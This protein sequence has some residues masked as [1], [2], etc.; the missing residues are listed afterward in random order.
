MDSLRRQTRTRVSL[1]PPSTPLAF[2]GEDPDDPPP[3]GT[4]AGPQPLSSGGSS[5]AGVEEQP[6]SQRSG[7]TE[8]STKSSPAA[9]AIGVVRRRK[10]QDRHYYEPFPKDSFSACEVLGTNQV[11]LLATATPGEL[12]QSHYLVNFQRRIKNRLFT[13]TGRKFLVPACQDGYP[14][15]IPDL[16][17]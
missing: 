11:V 7:R 3:G 14:Y 1:E 16:A 9:E 15:T 12:S 5:S 4:T 2:H 6:A 13:Q 8:H 10:V 17:A